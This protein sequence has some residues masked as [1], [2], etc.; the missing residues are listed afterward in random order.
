MST[1]SSADLPILVKSRAIV[2]GQITK[3]NNHVTQNLEDF[4]LHDYRKYQ[5]KLFELRK[6]N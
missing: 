3:T 5:D 2:R 4:T 6:K 1:S